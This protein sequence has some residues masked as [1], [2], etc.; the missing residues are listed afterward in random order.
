MRVK[1]KSNKNSIVETMGTMNI[2]KVL[3]EL[4]SSNIE[5]TI[6]EMVAASSVTNKEG[7]AKAVLQREAEG[8]T[9]IGNG[10]SIPHA[11]SSLITKGEAIIGRS[12][13]GIEWK[14]GKSHIVVLVLSPTGVSG[15][16]VI[17][18]SEIVKLLSSKESR[19]EIMEAKNEDEIWEVFA[20]L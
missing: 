3:L 9:Y 4:K 5:D 6:N 15:P 8:A 1:T 18:L 19:D 16:H 13:K 11:K 7:V 12:T 20:A 2:S 14:D 10:I 17:F